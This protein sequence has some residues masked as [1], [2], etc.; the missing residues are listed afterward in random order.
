[1]FFSM[2][3]ASEVFKSTLYQS[4]LNYIQKVED[5]LYFSDTEFV[6]DFSHIIFQYVKNNTDC[7][8]TS[9]KIQTSLQNWLQT[10]KYSAVPKV[11][12]IFKRNS[13]WWY[14]SGITKDL[15]Y[16]F[17]NSG[18]WQLW[19]MIFERR[20]SVNFSNVAYVWRF[21]TKFLLPWKQICCRLYYETK[22]RK[23]FLIDIDLY[24]YPNIAQVCS[25]YLDDRLWYTEIQTSM[26]QSTLL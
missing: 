9:L 11:H 21:Y 19:E 2:L 4:M 12:S 7:V 18:C 15:G 8:C 25:Q 24:L 14:N 6:N 1:M 20:I 23:T 16:R 3:R 26:L 13:N 17:D 5:D 22:F 10:Y